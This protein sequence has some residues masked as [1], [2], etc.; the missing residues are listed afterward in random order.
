MARM[1]FRDRRAELFGRTKDLQALVSRAG[2]QGITAVVGRPQ[3][4]KSWLLT[5]LARLLST[6][7][8][9]PYCVG[10][11]SSS[12]QTPDLL[13]RAV[14]DLYTRWLS[15]STYVEQAKIVWEQQK[16]GL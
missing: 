16:T 1:E 3:M 2:H 8:N 15:D 5:E 14:V 13:L 12:G 9:R 7:F 6:D 4:G 10:F 11:T